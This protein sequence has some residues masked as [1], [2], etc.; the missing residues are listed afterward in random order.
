M[1]HMQK[2]KIRLFSYKMSRYS[3]VDILVRTSPLLTVH[4]PVKVRAA[5]N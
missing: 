2:K 4:L 5:K 3:Q 1:K